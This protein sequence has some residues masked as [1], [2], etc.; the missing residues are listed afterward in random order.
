LFI[1]RLERRK[2]IDLILAAAPQILED[3]PNAL[4]VI[5]GRDPDDW[6][7]RFRKEIPSKHH[8]RLI[9]LGEVSDGTRE[10]LFAHAQCVLFPSRYESFGLVPLEAFVHGC[11]VIATRAG[12]IPEV[13]DD[14][15][16][17][18]LVEPDDPSALAAAVGSILRD[19][20]LRARL[21]DGA[22]H[23]VKELSARN[24]AAHAVETYHRLIRGADGSAPVAATNQ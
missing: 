17:G 10:K 4:M 12:A 8:A 18:I 21:S 5:G 7:C 22:R 14:R 19:A 20:K 11:P 16:S 2:G 15:S 13:I 9:F 23:R 3:D 24:S 1:G 6:A